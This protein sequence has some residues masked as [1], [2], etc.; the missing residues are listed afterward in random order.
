MGDNDQTTANKTAAHKAFQGQSI[1]NKIVDL[2][3]DERVKG[4]VAF[5]KT[6]YSEFK[7]LANLGKMTVWGPERVV[8]FVT[9]STIGKALSLAGVASG[10]EASECVQAVA[11]LSGDFAIGST[12]TLATGGVAVPLTL[13]MTALDS[14]DVG[15][16]C[17]THD[18]K[19]VNT[20]AEAVHKGAEAREKIESTRKAVRLGRRLLRKK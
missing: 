15:K 3:H 11:N 17:F 5:A 18:G 6:E 7:T 9:A 20:V 1:I 16:S 10:K 12:L 2:S 19:V 4:S 8:T 14:Y 13:L